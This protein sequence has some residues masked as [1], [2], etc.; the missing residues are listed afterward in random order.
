MQQCYHL[1]CDNMERVTDAMIGFAAKTAK[2]LAATANQMAPTLPK[3]NS[4]KT[5]NDIS[6][7]Q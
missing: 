7:T 3:V 4:G 2:A 1:K 5:V 6:D